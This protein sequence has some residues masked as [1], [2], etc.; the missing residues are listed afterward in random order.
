VNNAGCQMLRPL[1]EFPLAEWERE[2]AVMLT[3]PFDLSRQAARHMIGAG[4][5]KIVN[6]A[7][8]ASYQAARNI[9]GYV[10]AKHG[11][12]GL[13]KS[14]CA[15]LA[16]HHIN[17]NAVAPG[18][19]K[20]DMTQHIFDEPGRAQE[21][22]GRVPAGRF[23][24]PEDLVGTVLFLCSSASSHIHGQIIAVDGGWMAR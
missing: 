13:T 16:P 18:L 14:L 7:S 3:A 10:A 4:G 17:V 5:G 24:D 1:M 9:V 19:F 12:V 6:I 21:L 2:I 15:E 22:A 23:G 8:V 20:T 11:V